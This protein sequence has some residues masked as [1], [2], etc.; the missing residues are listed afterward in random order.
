[1]QAQDIKLLQQTGRI[2]AFDPSGAHMAYAVA[3][4]D[5]TTKVCTFE[6]VGMI[7]TRGTWIRAQRY[8]YMSA[9]IAALLAIAKPDMVGTESFF[10]NSKL[11]SGVAVVPI[12]NGFIEAETYRYNKTE[13]NF[14]GPSTWR[15]ILGIKPV[16]TNGKRDYKVPTRQVVETL[17]EFK[18]PETILSNVTG[19]ERDL[20]HDV[21]DVMAIVQA[22]AKMHDCHIFKVKDNFM[23]DPTYL[24]AFK[25]I[26]EP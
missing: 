19:K 16:M 26:G 3:H 13:L 23:N 15:K 6:A 2:L 24:N 25:E 18:F 7:W 14:V 5:L 8:I 11:P 21:S 17:L 20:P 9:A 4:I 10:L 1:M 12:I 22:V